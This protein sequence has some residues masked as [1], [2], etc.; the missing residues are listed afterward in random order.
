MARKNNT[1]KI[2]SIEEQI[3]ELQEKKKNMLDQL[4]NSIGKMVVTE[5]GNTNQEDLERVIS[6][7]RETAISKLNQNPAE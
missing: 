5:W 3:K 7:L 4:H 2:K 1:E 6:E